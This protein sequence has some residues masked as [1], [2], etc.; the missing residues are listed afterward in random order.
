MQVQFH[1]ALLSYFLSGFL[2]LS[3]AWIAWR[4]SAL[5]LSTLGWLLISM[6]LWAFSDAALWMQKS[7]DAKTL[8]LNVM[9]IGAVGAPLLFFIFVMKFTHTDTFLTTRWL[10]LFSIVPVGTLILQWTNEFHHLIFSSVKIAELNSYMLAEVTRGPW[11]FINVFYSYILIGIGLFVLIRT[12]SRSSPLH[13]TQSLLILIGCIIPLLFSVY[14]EFRFESLHGLNLVSASFGISGIVFLFAALRTSLADLVPVARSHLI[15]T[16]HDGVLVLNSQNRVVDINPAMEKLLVG[17]PSTFI[18]KPASEIFGPWIEKAE[19]LLEGLESETE[20]R[21]PN[22][23]SRYLDLRATPLYD[24]ERRLNGRLLVFRE[25][26]ERKVVER[27][28]RNANNRM[29]AQLIEIGLLQSQL[30]EQ[31][32][33]DPLTNLFNRRYLEET[34]DRELARAAREGYPVCIIMLDIDHFKRINDAHGHE[35]GDFVLK[36]LS[37]V[38]AS[39]SRRGDFACRFGGEEF[40]VVMPN[41]SMDVA[42]ERAEALRQTLNSL[43]VP[44][45]NTLLTVTISMGVASHP[46]NGITR[47]AI[48]R[49][50]DKAMYAAKNA[51]RDHILSFDQLELTN[52]VN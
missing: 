26:T 19:P 33:R 30:R 16:M 50:A 44:F 10:I 20:M 23:P 5:G 35:A 41:I 1:P 48:L 25:I 38:L 29:Q 2:C 49:A 18:G 3:A 31:A 32:I 42:L 13:R 39:Q 46:T 45:Q 28:L 11:Y 24:G 9:I 17:E 40:I 4:R 7:I 34:L 51:G 14:S 22:D 47:D 36:A 27:K 37:D 15:E 21:A 6:A 12:S 52:D 43:R 8:W